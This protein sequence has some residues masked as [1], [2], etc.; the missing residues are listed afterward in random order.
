MD[1][2]DSNLDKKSREDLYNLI[3]ECDY[4]LVIVTTHHLGKE[5]VKFFDKMILMENGKIQADE[6]MKLLLEKVKYFIRY[7]GEQGTG[8]NISGRFWMHKKHNVCKFYD[9]IFIRFILVV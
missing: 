7:F 9:Y 2:D 4:D 5:N 3:G 1:E 6:N 8:R